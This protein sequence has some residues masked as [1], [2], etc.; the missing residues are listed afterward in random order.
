MERTMATR[1][2][3]LEAMLVDA[4]DDTFLHYA[5][6]MDD[7]GAGQVAPAIDRLRGIVA[8]DPGYVPTYFQLGKLLLDSGD[9][10][11]G[12]LVLESGIGVAEAAG[13]DHAADELR[14]LLSLTE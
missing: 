3:K 10:A 12:K 11:A 13:D 9:E 8:R 6:A 4:P 7:A 2:E 1:R 14:G 5:L